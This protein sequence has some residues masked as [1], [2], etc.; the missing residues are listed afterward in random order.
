MYTT[1][2]A[3]AK[4]HRLIFPCY[5][6]SSI[7][8]QLHPPSHLLHFRGVLLMAQ[9][10]GYIN[11]ALQRH[12][13]GETTGF[14]GEARA[15]ESARDVKCSITR[16]GC[17]SLGDCHPVLLQGRTASHFTLVS[18]YAS[19]CRGTSISCTISYTSPCPFWIATWRLQP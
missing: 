1:V 15:S 14:D 6:L 19:S 11:V 2:L 4:S 13:S 7:V 3:I 10:M 12:E 9:V 17:A 8:N 5:F 18:G 16:G